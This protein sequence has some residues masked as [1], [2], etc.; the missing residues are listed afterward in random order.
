MVNQKF[1]AQF[2]SRANGANRWEASLTLGETCVSR[3]TDE[4]TELSAYPFD[5]STFPLLNLPTFKL[6]I[7]P[8]LPR[9]APPLPLTRPLTLCYPYNAAKIARFRVVTS[10]M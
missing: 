2:P 5:L 8:T 6:S 3:S 7:P 1:H 10:R 9:S 4:N